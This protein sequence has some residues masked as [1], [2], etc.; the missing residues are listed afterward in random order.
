[1]RLWLSFLFITSAQSVFAFGD[2]PNTVE[3][4]DISKYIGSWYQVLYNQFVA[5][6]KEPDQLCVVVK[7][8]AVDNSSFSSTQYSRHR[9]PFG[10]EMKTDAKIVRPDIKDPGSF[11]VLFSGAPYPEPYLVIKL[12]PVNK[13]SG[14]YEYSV[15]TDSNAVSLYVYARDLHKFHHIYKK[16]VEQFC[17]DAGFSSYFNQPLESPQPPPCKYYDED[18]ERDVVFQDLPQV[19]V[20]P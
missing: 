7:Y 18:R 2:T 10:S 19:M 12:G 1:M 8:F 17:H 4:L 11:Q 20:P 9:S 16:E 5:K 15:V 6:S 13:E 14:L 3:T